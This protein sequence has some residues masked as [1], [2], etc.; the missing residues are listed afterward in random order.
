MGAGEEGLIA[1][2][3][4]RITRAAR[5]H[6]RVLQLSRLGLAVLPEAIGQLTG[7]TTL[8]LSGNQLTAL[9]EAIGQLT[10]LTTLDL[11]SNRL[12]VL[13]DAIGQLAGLITLDL[14]RNPQL[15]D[16]P[17]EV[18]ARGTQAVLAF[19][20]A[21]ATSSIERWHSKVLVVGEA[22]VGKTS[23]VKRLLGDVFDPANHQ[24]LCVRCNTVKG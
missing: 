21:R 15:S 7:L 12:T 22:T 19:L 14:S 8:D 2:A 4:R 23:L 1:V 20:R 10:A 11:S 13:P 16:P 18:I 24:S 3:R 6:W 5:E 9:P 17:P